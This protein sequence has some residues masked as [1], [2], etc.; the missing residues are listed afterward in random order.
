MSEPSRIALAALALLLVVAPSPRAQRAARVERPVPFAVGETLTFD[1]AW[2]TFFTAGTVVATVME[3]RPSY[4]SVAYYVVAE[5]RPTP[6]VSRLYPLYYKFD[7]LIDVYS[8]LSQRGSVYIEEGTR[9]QLRTTLFNRQT[10]KATFEIQP[11]DTPKT[12]SAVSPATQDALATL[13][14]IRAVPLKAGDRIVIPT[15]DGGMNYVATFQVAPPEPITVPFG[16][17]NA[18]KIAVGIVDANRQMVGG[19]M[20]IWI[21][22]DAR[23]YPV[24]LQGDLPVGTFGLSLRDAR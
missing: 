3:K 24:K 12:E 7:T 19:N 17:V 4:N 22:T 18:L 8:L 20:A 21:S 15:S 9:H 11:G 1:V 5:G 6:L 16:T 10:G 14:A 23:R 13:Y 2:S